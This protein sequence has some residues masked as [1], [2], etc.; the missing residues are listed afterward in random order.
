MKIESG[1]KLSP[2]KIC[3]YGTEGIGKSTLAS[4]APDPLFIDIEYGTN[5]LDVKRTHVNDW[6]DLLDS[7]DYV[8][9]NPNICKTLVIDTANAAEN[10]CIEHICKRE[11]RESL[12]SFDYGQGYL[13]LEKEYHKLLEKLDSVHRAG[14]H[15]IVIAHSQ[16]TKFDQP[17]EGSYDR[18]SL[19]MNKKPGDLLK[20]WVDGLFFLNYET[21]VEEQ[22]GKTKA[23]G[24]E[25]M[26]YTTHNA[27]WDAKSRYDIGDKLPLTYDS[28]APCFAFKR[29]DLI[30]AADSAGIGQD[31]L[32]EVLRSLGHYTGEGKTL[33]DFD[34]TWLNR[35]VLG[36]MDDFLNYAKG[37]N[38][39]L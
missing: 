17:S 38:D 37:D 30:E 15:I 5:Q 14:T 29:I 23:R 3:I 27:V 34:S 7:V 19:K 36:R 1:I 33:E 25:R 2:A 9:A 24:Q 8:A 22:N 12:G 32:F 10:L 26:I 21:F 13:H 18:Y 28:I 35:N 4:F 11:R 20:E 31:K 6:K 16:I 39:V